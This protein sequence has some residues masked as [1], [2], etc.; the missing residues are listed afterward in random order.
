MRR[1]GRC[2]A[3]APPQHSNRYLRVLG[4]LAPGFTPASAHVDLDVIA[5]ASRK[6][7]RPTGWLS[8]NAMFQNDHRNAIQASVITLAGVLRCAAISCANAANLLARCW[9]RARVRDSR[10]VGSREERCNC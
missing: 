4:R 1:W 5:T 6:P 2:P 9:T 8:V 10:R 3:G 7:I